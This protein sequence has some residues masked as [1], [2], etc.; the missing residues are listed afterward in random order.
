MRRS[1]VLFPQPLG[2]MRTVLRPRAT[3]SVIGA[4]TET[5]PNDFETS[6]SSRMVAPLG[7]GRIMIPT[8]SPVGQS[9]PCEAGSGVKARFTR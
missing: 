2:P 7:M 3:D 6:R 4:R 1:R 5:L 8:V 9:T